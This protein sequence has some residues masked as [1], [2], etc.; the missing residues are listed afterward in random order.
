MFCV[1]V[2]VVPDAARETFGVLRQKR[3]PAIEEGT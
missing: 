1:R 3:N 2:V